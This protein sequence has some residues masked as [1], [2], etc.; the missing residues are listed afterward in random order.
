MTILVV[1]VTH[2]K[3]ILFIIFIGKVIAVIK[4]ET[5]INLTLA[6]LRVSKAVWLGIRKSQDTPDLLKKGWRMIWTQ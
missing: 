2:N 3:L 5:Q 1:D 6:T 4:V